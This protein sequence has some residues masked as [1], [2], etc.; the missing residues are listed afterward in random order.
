MAYL[1]PIDKRGNL[2]HYE[3]EVKLIGFNIGFG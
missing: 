2:H 1:N 3:V